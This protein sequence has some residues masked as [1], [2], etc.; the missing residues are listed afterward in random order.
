MAGQKVKFKVE[1]TE[2]EVD[3]EIAEMWLTVKHMIEDLGEVTETVIPIPSIKVQTFMKVIEYCEHHKHDN[4]TTGAEE[5]NDTAE[6]S[7]WDEQFCKVEQSTLFELIL[8]ANYLE[9]K[10]LLDL[11]CST[12]ANMI[13]KKSPEE[14]RK[15]FNIKNDFTPEEEDQIR[16][17]YSWCDER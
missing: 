14:I 8:A 5:R 16:L 11:T 9:I 15:L 4:S 6:V 10:S 1:E 13:K 17:D 12:V 7:P 3:R 2:I